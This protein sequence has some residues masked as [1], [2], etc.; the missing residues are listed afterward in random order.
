M[1]PGIKTLRKLYAG[2]I[3]HPNRN[4]VYFY[5]YYEIP[6]CNKLRNKLFKACQVIQTFIFH[7]QNLYAG[8]QFSMMECYQCQIIK[9][10][11]SL[12]IDLRQNTLIDTVQIA[13]KNPKE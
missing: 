4:T 3:M 7:F 8:K 12:K 10:C 5:C 13:K 2:L 1:P 6:Y 11:D 9:N